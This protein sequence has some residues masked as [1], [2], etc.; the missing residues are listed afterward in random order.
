MMFILTI[1]YS[2]ALDHVVISE[3]YYDPINNEIGG[4]AV[5]LYNPTDKAIDIGNWVI[6]TKSSNHDAT[7]PSNR[8]IKPKS[9]F[10]VA[11]AD[12]SLNKDN[13]SWNNADYE[14]AMSL[15][16]TDAGAALMD[17]NNSIIDAVGWGSAA[18]LD[19]NLYEGN[20]ANRTKEGFSLQRRFLNEEIQDTNNNEID[21][22]SGIPNLQNSTSYNNYINSDLELN[23][24]ITEV[25]LHIDF[26][27]VEDDDNT[28]EGI[29]IIP[30][31]K[32]NRSIRVSVQV[33]NLNGLNN[34]NLRAKLD[35]LE[36]NLVLSEQI[37][38]TTAVY[39]GF[40]EIPYYFNSG[41]YKLMILNNLN[42]LS[43]KTL[44]ILPLIAIELDTSL[45]NLE[46]NGFG[47]AESLGDKNFDTKNNPTI[48]NIGNKATDIEI[49]GTPLKNEDSEINVN[50]I[51]YS[52]DGNNY[53]GPLGG[54]LSTEKTRKELNLLAGFN[55]LREFSVKIA[56]PPE[57]SSGNYHG[58][59]SLI[60]V[61]S[62]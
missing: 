15:A 13:E 37:N 54:I 12:W 7:I 6:A 28:V 48:K 53:G 17:A 24:V 33:S 36:N 40:I 49:Y 27:E 8:Y 34:I 23:L 38:S 41:N 18:N 61:A 51:R 62:T 1:K 3:V 47:E 39:E 21:F 32:E 56:V 29:Q 45:L 43:N 30:F 22:I 5:E 9:Y 42:P 20:P 2:L 35:Y 58:T 50:N 52:F 57:S 31:P 60:A 55:S 59:I 19:S 26:I 44:E 25:Q 46:S 10:L 16:N 14:E 11:D 4:E